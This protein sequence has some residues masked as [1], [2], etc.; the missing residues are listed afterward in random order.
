MSTSR[1]ALAVLAA[2]LTT[3]AQESKLPGIG[4][5]MQDLIAKQEIPGAVTVVVAKDRVL[6]LEATGSAD[7]ATKRPMTADTLFWIASMTKPVTGVAILM[8]QDDGKL[9][10]SDPVAKY[11]PGF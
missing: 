3:S 9:K 11:L 5:A 4:A 10:I 7:L 8:L 1:I 2:T 6:H